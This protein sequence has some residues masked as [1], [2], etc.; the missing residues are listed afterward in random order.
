MADEDV[1][2]KPDQGSRVC[3]ARVHEVVRGC[4]R[5]VF[6]VWD[7]SEVFG[8]Q[9]IHCWHEHVSENWQY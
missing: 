5:D 9:V 2:R 8:N 1:R 3:T 4:S 7:L 6:L